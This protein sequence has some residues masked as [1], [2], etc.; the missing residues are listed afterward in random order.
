MSLNVVT[1]SLDSYYLGTFT[2]NNVTEGMVTF[3]FN[4]TQFWIYGANRPNHGSYSVI[5]D[6]ATYSGY[7]GAGN[8]LFQQSLFNLSLSQGLHTTKLTNTA[9]G[10]L[11]V[12]I[13]M[14]NQAS[15]RTLNA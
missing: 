13:D 12:D 8:N 2:T 10:S 15:R 3:S 9:T 7:N 14:V 4:A 11:Y 6:G 1:H 5:V